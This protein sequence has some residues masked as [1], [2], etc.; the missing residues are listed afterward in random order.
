MEAEDWVTSN[1]ARSYFDMSV[2]SK[3]V[4]VIF[5]LN[6]NTDG[7]IYPVGTLLQ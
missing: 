7:K 3:S 5:N 1:V 2:L 4:N 6:L